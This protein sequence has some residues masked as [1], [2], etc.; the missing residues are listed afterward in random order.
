MDTLKEDTLK[1]VIKSFCEKCELKLYDSFWIEVVTDILEY[2]RSDDLEYYYN[3]KEQ[4]DQ[5]FGLLYEDSKGR[6][7][8]L[9]K[10][11]DP[12]NFLLTLLH[13]YVHL[14]DYKKLSKIRNNLI[15][16]ELQE[17][18]AFLYWTEF[19]A[20]YLSYRFLINMDSAKI[21]VKDVQ[22]EIIVDLIEYYSSSLKLDKYRAIDK[23]VR[24]YGSYLA[25]YDEFCTKVILYPKQ[26]YL[27]KTFLEIYKFF[28][29]YKTF[30]N[31]ILVYG[32]FN[33]L[34]LRI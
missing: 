1:E 17:D 2:I 4:I 12:V 14:C 20:T 13:E 7:I 6:W 21:Q 10:K 31:F 9:V 34:L 3:H 25:L 18:Y 33:D 8:V 32:D 24:S 29:K 16:R 28:K 11:Q 22:N 19:H 15:L 5:V 23:T 27:N 26:Y 30:D